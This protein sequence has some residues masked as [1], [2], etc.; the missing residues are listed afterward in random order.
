MDLRDLKYFE[1]IAELGHLG[2][3]A[4]Q[5]CRSAP[6]LTKCIRRLE[7]AFGAELFA[8]A[9]RGIRLTPAGEVLLERARLLRVDLA[10]TIRAM[11]AVSG[12][13][14]GHVRVGIAPTMA[15]YLLP[16]A[17]RSFLAEAKEITIQTVIGMYPE[18]QKSLKAGQIDFAFT[19]LPTSDE[20]I[21]HPII[22]DEV[23]VVAGSSHEV[24]RKRPGLQDLLAYRWVLPAASLEAETRQW[25]E[26]AFEFRGLPKPSVQIETN[27]TTLLPRLIAQTGLL[28]FISR[29]NLGSG[30]VGAPLKEVRLKATTM[31]REFG[32]IYRKDCYLS[33]AARRFISLLCTQGRN[34][35][36]DQTE[37]AKTKT[38][39]GRPPDAIAAGEKTGNR[40]NALRLRS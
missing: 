5:L 18:L 33:P 25:L 8:R 31:H 37:A 16:A 17:C 38:A 13:V 4:K 10:D 39:V 2:R 29:R 35:F 27:S 28:S 14:A 34:F 24:F 20:F 15:Q 12:G 9:G 40:V 11:D 21:S 3:A 7:R 22:E 23:V 32:V 26:R 19:A 6:A 30:R 1:T 36:S